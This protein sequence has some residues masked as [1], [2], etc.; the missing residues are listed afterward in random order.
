MVA[1]HFA[2]A[3]VIKARAPRVPSLLLLLAVQLPDWIWLILAWL[4]EERGR[5]ITATG[6]PY[7]QFDYAPY[8]HS[9]FWTVFYSLVVF[10]LFIGAREQRHWAVPLS[11]GVLSHWPL[12]WLVHHADLPLA[13][14]GPLI[15][16]GLGLQSLAPGAAHALEL[17]LLLAGWG[18]YY[19][20]LRRAADRQRVFARQG[21]LL[22]LA[23]WLALLLFASWRTAVYSAPSLLA[24]EVPVCCSRDGLPE[25]AKAVA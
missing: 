15:K 8:S 10:L 18:V 1:G 11:L 21:L 9:L 5:W 7:L 3:L 4:G 23:A 19:R 17:L 16:L 13:N 22:L 6:L 2:V 12:D 24:D 14:F 25:A 20:S